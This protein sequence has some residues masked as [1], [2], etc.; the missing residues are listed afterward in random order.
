MSI[1]VTVK[2]HVLLLPWASVAVLVTVVIPTGNA[3]PLA[4]TLTSVTPGQLS[5]AVTTKVTLLVQ[6]PGAAFT[7]RFVEQEIE[8][9]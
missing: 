9:G 3:L 1:T 6:T 5:A 8:G 2:L 7:T 4:G